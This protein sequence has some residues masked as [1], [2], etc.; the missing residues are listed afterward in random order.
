MRKIFLSILIIISSRA[1]AQDDLKWI[2]QVRFDKKPEV[3]YVSSKDEFTNVTDE[4]ASVVAKES[5]YTLSSLKLDELF[6]KTNEVI[7]KMGAKCYQLKFDDALKIAD[8][9]YWQY[10]NN[11]SYWNQMG[12]CFYLN[13]D[14]SKAIL[15]YNKSRDLDS[16][17][18]PAINNLGVV[19][20]KQAK[21]QKA[22][23]AF[24]KALELNSFGVTPNYNLA[25]L[26]LRF[27]VS[28]KALPILQALQKRSPN[29]IDVNSALASAYLISG[30]A[31]SAVGIYSSM[32]KVVAQRPWN[33]LNYAVA[34]KSINKASEAQ[35]LLAT[36]SGL[37]RADLKTY[38]QKVEKFV[39]N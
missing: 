8:E 13:S 28:S 31:A 30:D 5:L 20:V 39:R 10:K 2:N 22:L 25:R 38:M 37:E 17:Y 18:A 1:F 35:S 12:T 32:E 16:K 21:F 23:S 6:G 33:A 34:L 26:Y 7:V 36:V 15:Y 9:I 27:G 24:K 4:L 11:P 3:K 19:Y 29:D 14:Y